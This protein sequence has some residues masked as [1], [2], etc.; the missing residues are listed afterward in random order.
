MAEEKQGNSGAPKLNPGD[1]AEPDAPGTGE[2]VCPVCHG[3]RLVDQSLR[4]ASRRAGRTRRQ[5]PDSCARA[6]VPG[7]LRDS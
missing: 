1:E 7:R 5:G 4:G 3:T 2:N 6:A